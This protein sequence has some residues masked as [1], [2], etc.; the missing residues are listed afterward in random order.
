MRVCQNSIISHN[1]LQTVHIR[2]PP[3]SEYALALGHKIAHS[4]SHIETRGFTPCTT[5]QGI[6]L[7][8][9][10]PR[11]KPGEA[12]A[13]PRRVSVF[14]GTVAPLGYVNSF[15]RLPILRFLRSA[16]RAS[17]FCTARG[18]ICSLRTAHVK[19]SPAIRTQRCKNCYFHGFM[20]SALIP[21]GCSTTNTSY[22]FRTAPR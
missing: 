12:D 3:E 18:I 8:P 11:G 9:H 20:Y 7:L 13:S 5:V 2:F 17:L 16:H 4:G 10:H 19:K 15:V 22:F 14:S 6:C 21:L 1:L